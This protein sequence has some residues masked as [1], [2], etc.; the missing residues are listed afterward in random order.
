VRFERG[1]PRKPPPPELA[2]F[3]PRVLDVLRSLSK[4]DLS[5]EESFTKF[6]CIHAVAIIG[7]PQAAD[8]LAAAIEGEKDEKLL[9]AGLEALG[10]LM[11]PASADTF[12]KYLHHSSPE[13]RKAAVFNLGAL[14][15]TAAVDDIKKRLSDPYVDVRWN[16]AFVLAQFLSDPSGVPILLEMLDRTKVDA[17]VDPKNA[18]RDENINKAMVL[19][20]QALATVKER[21]AIPALK[22]AAE[23][24]PSGQVRSAARKALEAV[25]R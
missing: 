8:G 24:D 23:S 25:E 1:D 7:D 18:L 14:R 22:K 9:Y 21:S 6:M 16:A 11:N 19:A 2:R 17:A 3:G 13:V 5:P 4:R 20:A 10:A 15:N 12:R